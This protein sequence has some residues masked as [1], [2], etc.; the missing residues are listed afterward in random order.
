MA[1]VYNMID[2][3]VDRLIFNE[4]LP[5]MFKRVG[6]NTSDINDLTKTPNWFQSKTWTEKEESEFKEWLIAKLRAKLKFSKTLA[7]KKAEYF[8]L[9]Y[10][11]STGVP[12][13]LELNFDTP[14]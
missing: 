9:N 6:L 12:K 13:Q 1:D 4:L 11:W 8:L 5:E 2:I 7:T 3:K 14:N 10:G